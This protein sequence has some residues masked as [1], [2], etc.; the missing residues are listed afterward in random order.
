MTETV[1]DNDKYERCMGIVC[2]LL[3]TA[4]DAGM[5]HDEI[6]YLG[7]NTRLYVMFSIFENIENLLARIENELDEDQPDRE[8]LGFIVK[9]ICS[10]LEQSGMMNS[11]SIA[12]RLLGFY[13]DLSDEALSDLLDDIS[14]FIHTDTVQDSLD[15]IR[16]NLATSLRTT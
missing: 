6:E 13:F 7:H 12:Y 15:M 5:P 1:I 3:S 2:N 11:A 14:D 10:C 9:T 16:E 8:K 4:L